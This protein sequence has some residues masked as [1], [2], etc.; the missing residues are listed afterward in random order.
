ME[1]FDWKELLSAPL[2][3]GSEMA[4]TVLDCDYRLLEILL[5]RRSDINTP[6][7][8]TLPETENETKK[9]G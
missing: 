2:E 6:L 1:D 9:N 5:S 7:H 3:K 8:R 4:K